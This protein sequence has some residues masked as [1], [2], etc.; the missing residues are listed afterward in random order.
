MPGD[1]GKARGSGRFRG[2][3]TAPA[4]INNLRLHHPTWVPATGFS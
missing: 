4:I 1:S 2:R 3:G